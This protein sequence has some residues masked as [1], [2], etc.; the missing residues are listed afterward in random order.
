[1]AACYSSVAS[2]DTL[3]LLRQGSGS[4]GHDARGLE[5]VGTCGEKG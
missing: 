3:Q 5:T 1:M 4:A 2:V